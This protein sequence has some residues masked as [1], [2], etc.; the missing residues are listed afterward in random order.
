MQQICKL[1]LVNV[2]LKWVIPIAVMLSF[3]AYTLY[4]QHCFKKLKILF[5]FL[6]SVQRYNINVV[7]ATYILFFFIFSTIPY[8]RVGK[9]QLFWLPGT[10]TNR[11]PV[12]PME[13]SSSPTI[14]FNHW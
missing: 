12:P 6:F 4:I 5:V 3:T 13:K 10:G 14:V 8:L 1:F 11:R 2:H 9:F 7:Y